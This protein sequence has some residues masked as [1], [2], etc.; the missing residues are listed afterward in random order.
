M[1]HVLTFHVVNLPPKG[2]TRFL[3]NEILVVFHA[4]TKGARISSL[5][6]HQKLELVEARISI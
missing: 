1:K 3:P 2:E 6:R 4:G 5:T